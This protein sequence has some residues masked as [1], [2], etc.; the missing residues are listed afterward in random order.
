MAE[1][2][3]GFFSRWRTFGLDAARALSLFSPI[4]SLSLRK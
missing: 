2:E 3:G 4:F 1:G